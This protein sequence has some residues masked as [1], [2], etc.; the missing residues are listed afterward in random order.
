MIWN[1]AVRM[2]YAVSRDRMI[3]VVGCVA[4]QS[5]TF[6]PTC[7]RNLLTPSCTLKKQAVGWGPHNSGM[8]CWTT[9]WLLSDISRQCSGPRFFLDILTLKDEIT[10]LSC[11]VRQQSP[12]DVAS[13]PRSGFI[14]QRNGD[15]NNTA[16]EDCSSRLL[17]QAGKILQDYRVSGCRSFTV[18]ITRTWNLV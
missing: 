11:I 16:A 9:G 14:S 18:T 7:Q 4:V 13:H 1:D 3:S 2:D 17:L 10:T 12:C 6:L 8:R 15:L 5:G